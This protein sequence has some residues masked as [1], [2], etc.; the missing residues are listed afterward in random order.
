M[1]TQPESTLVE[2]IRYNAWANQQVLAACRNASE[3]QLSAK[4]PGAYGSIRDTLFHM[5]WAEGDYINR[6]TGSRPMPSSNWEV[7]SPSLDEFAAY[8]A[9]TGEAFLDVVQRV[10]PTQNVHEEENGF[11]MDYHARQ[12]FMQVVNHGIEHRT[13]IT[14]YLAGQGLPVP[15]IDNWGYMLAHT[16]TFQAKQGKVDA[17]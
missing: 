13:N 16:D 14:T 17:E 1:E 2:F 8:A 11:T 9:Q 12:L 5:L 10:P 15:E 4:I 6:I 7:A 3:A